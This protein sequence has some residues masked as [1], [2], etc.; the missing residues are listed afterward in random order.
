MEIVEHFISK[1][2]N[3]KYM[4]ILAI[5]QKTLGNILIQNP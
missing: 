4:I 2:C 3:S 5:S 1:E